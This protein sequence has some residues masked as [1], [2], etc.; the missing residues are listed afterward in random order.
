[1][2]VLPLLVLLLGSPSV[3]ASDPAPSVLRIDLAAPPSQILTE[4]VSEGTEYAV[5]MDHAIPDRARYVYD[6]AVRIETVPIDAL[7]WEGERQL[8][9]A[10]LHGLSSGGCQRP[11][12]RVEEAVL[13]VGAAESEAAVRDSLS[14]LASAVNAVAQTGCKPAAEE[15][16][17]QTRATTEIQTERTYVLRRG[18][19]M[20]VTVTRRAVGDG[21]TVTWQ[22]VYTTRPRGRWVTSLG[23]A[24]ILDVVQ[25]QSTFFADA[26]PADS[27]GTVSYRLTEE[28]DR[29]EYLSPTGAVF[30]TWLP[31]RSATR[32]WTATGSGFVGL[33]TDG[34]F[35]LGAA[36]T[37]AF[38]ENLLFH[39]GAAL[40]STQALL[41]RYGDPIADSVAVTEPLSFDQ[42]HDPVYRFNPFFALTFR[43]GGAAPPGLRGVAPTSA[44]TE[45]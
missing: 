22:R 30:F 17:S 14:A 44:A 42:L 21:G 8:P 45:E 7:T 43:F 40:H 11:L 20:V 18:E 41:G 1:M 32:A 38:N 26:Q 37:L 27:A 3:A 16:L 5:R 25:R 12:E 24:V 2:R 4:T 13:A 34:R 15:A 31:A 9:S 36:G 33:S 6:V 10:N 23:P 29:T 28:E 19:R 35:T 39:A